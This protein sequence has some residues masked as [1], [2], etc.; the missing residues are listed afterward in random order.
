MDH[1]HAT[2]PD[3]IADETAVARVAPV[4]HAHIN[5]L[6]RHDLSRAA[7]ARWPGSDSFARPRDGVRSRGADPTA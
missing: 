4:A 1:L 2:T 3:V 6:G 5:S 7:T